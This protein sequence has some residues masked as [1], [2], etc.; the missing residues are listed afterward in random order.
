MWGCAVC[1]YL[2]IS[3]YLL[4]VDEPQEAGASSILSATIGKNFFFNH[5]LLRI[6]SH[7]VSRIRTFEQIRRLNETKLFLI[8][9]IL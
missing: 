7:N 3:F 1:V 4:Y 2:N 6:G 9:V 8:L 5:V